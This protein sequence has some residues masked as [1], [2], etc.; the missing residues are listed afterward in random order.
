MGGL[1]ACRG[2][3]AAHH[4]GMPI[5]PMRA[6]WRGLRQLGA[7]L[8]ALLILFEEWGWEPLQRMMARLARLRWVG[9][10]EAAIAA[11]P[12]V[13]ALV[14]FALPWALLLPVKLAALALIAQGR[15]WLGLAVILGA[16]LL[17]TALLARLF[18]L[19]RPAL[20]RLDWF[21]HAYR[22]WSAW[23][24]ALLAWV[25][26]S[27]VWRTARALRRLAGRRWARR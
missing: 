1:R 26:A 5:D 9:R 24:S 25:R 12:P 13:A 3:R 15:P 20:L 27:A 14:L 11:L 4:A 8:L 10:L 22:R 2:G 21:A 17:G 23:K 18:A 6:L 19:T 7:A 16:K